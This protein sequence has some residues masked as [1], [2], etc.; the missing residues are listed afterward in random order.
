MFPFKSKGEKNKHNELLLV[1]QKYFT[2]E[3]IE[4]ILPILNAS[5]D[6]PMTMT[7]IN[8]FVVNYSRENN[9]HVNVNGKIIFINDN[10][11]DHRSSNKKKFFDCFCREPKIDF[12]YIKNNKICAIKTSVGQL[13]FYKWALEFP[14]DKNILELTKKHIVGIKKDI[15]L[16]N[17]RKLDNEYVD[18]TTEDDTTSSIVIVDKI[19]TGLFDDD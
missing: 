3:N 12:R 18:D 1:M 11:K 13:N 19:S 15:K 8:H 14:G 4:K 6:V 2:Y 17:K 10:Y 16:R 7:D 9:I 5:P